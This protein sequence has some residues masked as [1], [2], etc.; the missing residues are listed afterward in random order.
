MGVGGAIL[1]GLALSGISAMASMR[2]QSQARSAASMQ[3]QQSSMAAMQA[4]Q[5]QAQQQ[6][7]LQ[8]QQLETDRKAQ[9][10]KY[11][12]S[13]KIGEIGD[14]TP[15]GVGSILTSPLGAQDELN[16]GKTTLLGN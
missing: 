3:Q 12:L 11:D 6:Q 4:A 8:Q 13:K 16:L 15:R 7:Q 2:Q 10:N 1:G 5:Q 14:P 9:Q